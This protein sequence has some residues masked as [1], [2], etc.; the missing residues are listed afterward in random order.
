M[1]DK[2][3]PC[4][5][6]PPNWAD[7]VL[8]ALEWKS[9]V[10]ISP[11]GAEQRR[12]LRLSPRR[13]I[14]FQV[15]GIGNGR[16]NVDLAVWSAGG[17]D[18]NMPLWWDYARLT[19]AASGSAT[20]LFM[21]TT[22]SEFEAGGL[23][24]VQGPDHE[25]FDVVEIVS[26]AADRLNLVAP[27]TSRAWAAGTRVY[28]MRQAQLTDQPS[29]TR[30]ND[31]VAT[32]SVSWV[33]TEKNVYQAVAPTETYLGYKV[34]REAPN[35]TGALSVQWSRMLV[36]A[37]NGFGL[38]YRVDTANY[39]FAR[40][41]HEFFINGRQ[42]HVDFRKLL[43][44]LRGRV[45]PV[46]VPTF[47]IDMRLT[48]PVTSLSSSLTIEKVGVA[49]Y[50]H[51]GIDPDHPEYQYPGRRH[52][53]LH[54]RD[55]S[56]VFAI[57]NNAVDNIDGTETI[58]LSAPVGV[59]IDPADIKRVSFIALMRLDQDRVEINHLTDA[60]G[61]AQSV[62]SWVS[63]P[64]NRQ[65]DAWSVP[66]WEG[67]MT[68]DT[69]TLC[70]PPIAK[71]NDD[72]LY[73]GGYNPMANE[74][75]TTSQGDFE[76][77]NQVGYRYT[78]GSLEPLGAIEMENP[79]VTFE[80]VDLIFCREGYIPDEGRQVMW[81]FGQFKM[82]GTFTLKHCILKYD[83]L[84]G[85]C[86]HAITPTGT[87][88][89]GSSVN[90]ILLLSPTD[91]Q[92]WLVSPSSGSYYFHK[93]DPDTLQ[94]TASYSVA[95]MAAWSWPIMDSAGNIWWIRNG[96]GAVGRELWRFNTTTNTAAKMFDWPG[97]LYMLMR[98][99]N[100]E[101]IVVI[102]NIIADGMTE[103]DATGALTG[104]V[105]PQPPYTG[106]SN[107]RYDATNDVMWG[108]TWGG[109]DGTLTGID[110][111]DGSTW[112]TFNPRTPK[113]FTNINSLTNSF[114]PPMPGISNALYFQTEGYRDEAETI[115]GYD[116][117]KVPICNVVRGG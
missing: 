56:A 18:W 65:A 84:T 88:I 110:M 105:L 108:L 86:L 15:V 22:Y 102:N 8:E 103:I 11:K 60:A 92:L 13:T 33:T 19:A 49:A 38:P 55:G 21:D 71:P 12:M 47:S 99:P 97:S 3:L 74:I 58:T 68:A 59:N 46:W 23:A 81:T 26:V 80:W 6:Y 117:V 35:E 32:Y 113:D 40:Q 29:L 4:W 44:W 70:E 43:Y 10:A 114:R 25:T 79:D 96:V 14:E 41:Q 116:M 7:G 109:T 1:S 111:T 24:F 52:I 20:T 73:E 63:T 90:W 66:D 82:P 30:H 62:V 93:I 75:W 107:I 85:E 95:S 98:V 48:A 64:E 53:M 16:S 17:T 69:C 37:D 115:Y 112:G 78:A 9:S 87:G 61:V 94:P 54:L 5:S 45:R 76:P 42:E 72:L 77:Y 31:N 51:F 50:V 2:T 39:G 106:S 89:H 34:Y 27:G 104:R 100:H 91:N 57:M 36:T 67:V 101:T 83:A 28:P